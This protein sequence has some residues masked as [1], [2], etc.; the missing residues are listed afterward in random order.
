[1]YS[2]ILL[3]LAFTLLI[4]YSYGANNNIITIANNDFYFSIYST[5]NSKYFTSDYT[6]YTKELR[7]YHTKKSNELTGGDPWKLSRINLPDSLSEKK[8]LIKKG[9]YARKID[10]ENSKPFKINNFELEMWG[11]GRMFP[12]FK[13]PDNYEKKSQNLYIVSKDE[14]L[15]E[16]IE[17]QDFEICSNQSIL[18]SISNII[19]DYFSNHQEILKSQLSYNYTIYDTLS[20]N[21]KKNVISLLYDLSTFKVN[22][23]CYLTIAKSKKSH[24]K[25][26][27]LIFPDDEK[28]D[29]KIHSEFYNSFSI[30]GNLFFYSKS[31]QPMTGGVGYYIYQLKNNKLVV[32]YQD[33]SFAM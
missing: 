28:I 26:F 10:F 27:A 25:F 15:L 1:M 21:D 13:V 5:I 24:L 7:Q 32:I 4:I 22:E 8:L 14:Q 20:I 2:K 9:Y 33:G 23:K 17:L 30:E 11:N 29:L 19:N 16:N 12:S 18:L 3:T 31:S 6:N